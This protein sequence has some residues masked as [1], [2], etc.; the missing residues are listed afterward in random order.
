MTWNV[1]FLG[2]C[3]MGTCKKCVFYFCWLKC[4]RNVSHIVLCYCPNLLYPL[5]YSV[6]E[7]LSITER[8][9][10]F[11]CNCTVICLFLLSGWPV[12]ASVF[13]AVVKCICVQHCYV[14]LADWPLYYYE[15]TFFVTGNLPCSD[16]YFDMSIATLVFLDLVFVWYITLHHF[17]F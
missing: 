3:F 10:I 4:S 1:V 9:W 7:L 5:W 2:E 16:T 15:M 8:C 13:G 11:Y 6:Y 17:T 12:A 14:F